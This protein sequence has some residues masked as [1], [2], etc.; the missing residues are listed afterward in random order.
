MKVNNVFKLTIDNK[1]YFCDVKYYKSMKSLR[2]RVDNDL[3]ILISAP[4]NTPNNIL[5]NFVNDHKLDVVR[6]INKK[7]NSVFYNPTNNLIS[8]LGRQHQLIINEHNK[9]DKYE[10]GYKTVNLYL[11]NKNDVEKLIRKLFK[12]ESEKYIVNR[13]KEIAN[14]YGFDVKEIKIKWMVG[15]WGNC[16]KQSKTISF[17]SR[18]ITF[19]KEIIDYVIVHE[20]CHLYEANH[21][22]R[23]WQLVAKIYPQYKF[24]RNYMKNF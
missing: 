7:N 6:I 20:M 17:S 4:F 8:I 22:D 12:K 2:L 3:R 16:R 21:S 13:A 18:L 24:A 15:C 19:P 10:I 14:T 23:F 9:N 11:K 5:M 1:E